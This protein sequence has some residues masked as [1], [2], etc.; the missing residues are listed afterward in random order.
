MPRWRR[1][2]CR[3]RLFVCV[4][5]LVVAPL[6]RPAASHVNSLVAAQPLGTRLNAGCAEGCRQR[7]GTIGAAPHGQSWVC[8]CPIRRRPGG[9]APRTRRA[10]RPAAGASRPRAA[11]AR[12]R[13]G[14]PTA[15]RL[16]PAG[17]A[18]EERK[19]G[20]KWGLATSSRRGPSLPLSTYAMQGISLQGAS[21]RAWPGHSCASRRTSAVMPRTSSMERLT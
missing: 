6:W 11:G 19:G 10:W 12:P 3:H 20:S 1:C 17:M 14:R 2:C 13:F 5:C 15:R 21:L 18:G 4:H 8:T 7:N 16:A 9:G